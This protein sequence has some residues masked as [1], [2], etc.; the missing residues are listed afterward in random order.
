MC[1]YKFR[2]FLT[3]VRDDLPE[4]LGWIYAVTMDSSGRSTWGPILELP[5]PCIYIYIF[6]FIYRALF[7]HNL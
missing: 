2:H 4:C 3:I 7:L 5:Q 1:S 6:I